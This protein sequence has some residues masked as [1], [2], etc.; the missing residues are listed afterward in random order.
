MSA[1]SMAL[2][3]DALQ[4]PECLGVLRPGQWDLLIRQARQADV[5][6]RLAAGAQHAGCWHAIPP[7]PRMHLASARQLALRQHT[8]LRHEVLE[9]ERALQPVGL[10]VV[11]LKGAAY[12]LAGLHASRGRRVSDVDILVPRERLAD[13]ESALMMAGWVSTNRDAYDQRYYRTWMHEL[14]PL[15]HMRRG[16]VLDVHHAILPLTARFK[17]D[18][19]ALLRSSVAVAGREGIRVLCRADMVLHSAAHLFH[20]GE[21]EMGLRGLVDLDAL[22]REFAQAPDF[23]DG[24]VQ[25]ARLLDLEWPL[26]QAIRYTGSVLQTPVPA[27][28]VAPLQQRLSVS[29]WRLRWMDAL[30]LRALRP[31]HAS[32]SDAWTPLARWALYLRGHWLRMPPGLLVVHLLRKGLSS[33]YPTKARHDQEL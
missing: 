23:W 31:D 18:T 24:L 11:L 17:P 27:R 16:S 25:R 20:E 13:V 19:Q 3:V 6:A 32:V 1:P 14:P 8:E 33:A 29:P 5:L 30:Y 12:A 26:F 2:L 4:H 7:Q 10:P 21:L 22:L 28:V 9:I 15:R